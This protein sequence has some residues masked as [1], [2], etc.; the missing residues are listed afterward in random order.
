MFQSNASFQYL[1]SFY[2]MNMA[3]T[4]KIVNFVANRQPIKAR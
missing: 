1:K 2:D 4:T 3:K